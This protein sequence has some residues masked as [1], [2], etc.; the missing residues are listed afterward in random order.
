MRF[1]L[2]GE[3][4]RTD[5]WQPFWE[6]VFST[7]LNRCQ[8]PKDSSINRPDIP[9]IPRN[10][11]ARGTPKRACDCTA[12]AGENNGTQHIQCVLLAPKNGGTGQRS[13]KAHTP[14]GL[15]IVWSDV[16]QANAGIGVV[17]EE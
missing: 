17:M 12:G 16:H 7:R 2:D 10:P 8:A 13:N 1:V 14:S 6:S 9:E 11:A 4:A 3:N 15:V 5:F